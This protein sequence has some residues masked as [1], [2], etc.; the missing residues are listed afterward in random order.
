MYSFENDYSEGA[1]NQVLQAL[2]QTNLVQSTGYGLDQFCDK[3]R[4]LL[5][6]KIGNENIDIHFVT[7]GTPANV[8]AIS[9][10][11]A[12]EAVIA[13]ESA[14]INVHET[15]AVEAI[16]HKI[17][18]VKGKQGKITPEAIE[19]V[20]L[21]HGDEHMVK[22]KMVFISNAT[23]Y[24]TIYTKKELIEI[25]KMCR[26]YDL[27]LYMDGA[28]LAN[29]LACKEND[30]TLNDIAKLVDIFYIGATKNGALIGEA[31]IVVN[32]ELKPDFR[33]YV[34][35]HCAMLAKARIIGIEFIALLQE[36]LYLKLANN[37]NAMAQALKQ[38]FI[39]YNCPLYMN[40]VTNQIFVLLDNEILKKIKKKY[41]VTEFAK[42]N[43]KTTIVRFVCSWATKAQ[44]V[45]QFYKDFQEIMG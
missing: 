8:V 36:D 26:K 16:G 6:Q 14:H 30:L 41:V 12:H 31:M 5:K 33:Y 35:Q 34:K 1:C 38:I 39:K 2:Q 29:A 28:R 27:Y 40:S 4:A 13:V 15:G 7:G 43:E 24:G 11:M 32:D 18:A 42:Y 17:I 9:T 3:A 19:K 44:A 20:V 25:A 23:E 45:E 22:P 37:A 21:T 10:L